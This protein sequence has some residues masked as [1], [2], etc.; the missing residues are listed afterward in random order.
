MVLRRELD[1]ISLKYE[2]TNKNLLQEK[3]DHR[4]F[5]G[6]CA[7]LRLTVIADSAQI[8]RSRAIRGTM[9]FNDFGSVIADRLKS[10]ELIL[11]ADL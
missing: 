10:A 11:R 7:P 5:P 4:Y 3:I 8:G 9:G 1:T 2:Y 6:K